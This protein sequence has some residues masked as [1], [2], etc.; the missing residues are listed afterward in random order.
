MRMIFA[1]VSA[2]IRALAGLPLRRS[3][4]EAVLKFDPEGL[5]LEKKDLAGRSA[6]DDP[7]QTR[8]LKLRYRGTQVW[9]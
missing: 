7:S 6:D 1:L 9:K 5:S 4:Q 2:R 3:E 8:S